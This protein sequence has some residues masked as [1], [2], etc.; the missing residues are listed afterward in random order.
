M[1]GNL[2]IDGELEGPAGRREKPSASA[3]AEETLRKVFEKIPAQGI[4]ESG[5]E[6]LDEN[7][8]AW[9]ARWRLLAQAREKLDIS[10]FILDADI[11]GISFLGHL[12]QK[13]REGVRVRI[14]LDAIG[15]SLSRE[16]S[17]NDY[18]DT[19]AG[20]PN[21]SIKIYRPYTT[22]FRDAFLMLNPLALLASDHDKILA[23]DRRRAIIGGRNIAREYLADPV[24]YPRAFRDIDALFTGREIGNALESVFEAGFESAKARGVR[25]EAVDLRDSGKD[26]LLAYE[27]MDAWLKRKKVPAKTAGTI[28][29]RG[30]SWLEDLE[31]LPR[32]RGALRKA[33]GPTNRAEIR[34]LDSRPRLLRSDDAISRGLERV[35]G[36]AQKEILVQTPYLILSGHAVSVLEKAAARGVSIIILTNSPVSTD[37]P[38]SQAF[39]LEQWPALLARVPTLRLFVAGDKHNIHAKA[40]VIDRQL[41]L[42]GTYNLDPLSMSMNGE[43]VAAVWSSEVAKRM[44]ANPRRLIAE[45]APRV[46]EYRIVR[47][48]RGL[49]KRDGNGNAVLAFGPEDH[50]SPDQ[51]KT[52]QWYRRLLRIAARLPGTAR[53]FWN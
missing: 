31:K 38:L 49:P 33:R 7:P 14:L 11:F 20:T 5:I 16:I 6:L 40:A 18:L 8:E 25:R 22:R 30:L 27:A 24:D 1:V 48:A 17:G 52:V 53:L 44:A 32:L 51:W 41:A 34:L 19:L 9:A 37:N 29:E 4:S 47:D 28:R 35:A 50:S 2:L 45:G 36:G 21:V 10:Y 46:Y 26:L 13:A 23:A 43:L 12:L 3:P 42:I 39:F 15:T